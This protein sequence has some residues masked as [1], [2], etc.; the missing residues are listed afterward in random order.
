MFILLTIIIASSFLLA[1]TGIKQPADQIN[2]TD[3]QTPALSLKEQCEGAN[4]T[5]IAEHEECEGISESACKEMNGSF[6]ECASACR[7]EPEDT[8]CTTQCVLVCEFNQDDNEDQKQP[9]VTDPESHNCTEQ[10]MSAD[11]CTKEYDPVCGNDGETY[12]N[13]CVACSTENV[14]SWTKGE[15]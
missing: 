9:P 14:T 13:G 1:C 2:E 4:G 6:N 12:S 11:I 10:E 8:I 7:H 3:D 15:C 5:W